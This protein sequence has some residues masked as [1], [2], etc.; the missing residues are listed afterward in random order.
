VLFASTAFAEGA[1]FYN[2]SLSIAFDN[3]AVNSGDNLK[4]EFTI[5]N[6]ESVAFNDAYIVVE[7]SVIDESANRYPSQ[8][9]ED[10]VIIEKKFDA[11][12]GANS[13]R[14]IPFEIA[15]PSNLSGG[16][17]SLD[18][19]FRTIRAPVKGI[20]HIFASPV[21]KEF[22][23]T[24][25]GNFPVLAIIRAKTVFNG[26]EGPVGSP[27]EPNAIISGNVFV[28]NS[29]KAQQ[30]AT[31][32]AGLCTWDDT[33]CETFNSTDSK[34]IDVPA[35][36]ES[37]VALNLKGSSLPGA[38][39]IRIEVRDASGKMISLY[40]NR[41]IIVGP[42]SRIRKLDISANKL[43]VGA[44]AEL[45]LLLGSSPD[46]YNNPDFTDFD[47]R[48]WVEVSGKKIF[49]KTEHIDNLPFV[50]D[51]RSYS[52]AFSSSVLAERFKVCSSVEKAGQQMD[53]YCFDVMPFEDSPTVQE[54]RVEVAT[55]Y[56][57]G[58]G[59]LKVT[60]CGFD[61]VNEKEELNIALRLTDDVSSK[62]IRDSRIQQ[63]F[64]LNDS[65]AVEAK[66]YTLAV[67]DFRNN[68]QVLKALDFR[69]LEKDS[70][71]NLDGVICSSGQMCNGS[72]I[73]SSSEGVC[74]SG[75][76]VTEQP[77][78]VNDLPSQTN[79]DLFPLSIAIAIIILGLALIV[80]YFIIN[81]GND[82]GLEG[83]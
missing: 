30:S 65:V 64:C 41:A 45:N 67:D 32:W 28:K 71:N 12:V 47:A 36:S 27:I 63:G 14:T 80:A 58:S 23:V 1:I 59:L 29:A 79:E 82:E 16:K 2:G 60:V 5:V 46:H 33:S 68:V 76:C 22:T 73:D 61:G 51:L 56:N 78:E 53:F 70:C 48:V 62:K 13:R 9:N 38:Y 49:E 26:Q 43:S 15:L 18:V 3:S 39:A 81:R 50:E 8:F 77:V 75:T 52:F 24:G 37:S 44:P 83:L 55:E 54:G 17:Y 34:Q 11:R 21:R 72:E 69:V 42:T 20:P 57:S 4:G 25:S 10:N 40:R 7:V 6:F 74:C 31:V 19:Y 35:N 66:K